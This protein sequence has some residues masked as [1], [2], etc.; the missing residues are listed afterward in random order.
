MFSEDFKLLS[1]DVRNILILMLFAPGGFF[2]F[3]LPLTYLHVGK[4]SIIVL[5]THSLFT[6]LCWQVPRGG[7]CQGCHG[8]LAAEEILPSSSDLL[9]LRHLPSNIST[10]LQLKSPKHT[11]C[12]SDRSVIKFVIIRQVQGS[13]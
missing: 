3:S 12:L 8:N 10:G 11:G 4:Y 1:K 5:Y 9:P 7:L 6:V 13:I 2:V